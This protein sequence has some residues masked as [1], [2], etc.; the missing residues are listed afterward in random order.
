MRRYD[1]DYKNLVTR[2]N[3]AYAQSQGDGTVNLDLFEKMDA[4]KQN[5]IENMPYLD[6]RRI[7]SKVRS[8]VL[9]IGYLTK[10][11]KQLLEDIQNGRKTKYRQV[12]FRLVGDVDIKKI[13]KQY[14]QFM[15]KEQVF[16]T[17]YL[18]KGLQE[19]V[20]VVCENREQVFPIHDIRNLNHEK[21]LFFLK[22]VLA[23]G[24][25]REFHIEDD[26]VLCLQGYL[27]GS[28]EMMVV[29]SI[30]PYVAYPTGIRGMLYKIFDGMRPES[31]NVP[32]I[33]EE[34]AQKI[35][36]ERTKI[37]KAKSIEYWKGLMLPLGKSMK[38]PGEGAE[39]GKSALYKGLDD[40]L[41]QTLTAFC[42]KHH[43]S[44]KAA[45][46]FAWGNL[47]GKYHDEKNP[48]MLVAQNGNAMNLFPIK[49]KRDET[50]LENMRT[51]DRQL[52]DMMSYSDC[53]TRDMESAVGICFPEYFRMVHSFI[54]FSELDDI[55]AMGDGMTT[56]RGIG[57]DD[58][59]INLFIGYRLFDKNIG[60]HYT[61]RSGIS[62][63]VLE[64]LHELFVDELS[65]M[66]SQKERKFDKNFFI[67]AGDTDE[68]KLYKISLAQI[69]LYLKDSGVFESVTVDEIMQLAE[70][71][72][73]TTYLSNDTVIAERSGTS[74]I[75]ILGDGTVEESI[76]AA[77]GMVKS[78][79]IIKKGSV[80]G[81]E[82]LLAGGEA[83]TTYTVI[84]PQAKIVEIDKD[85]LA[86]VFRRKPEGW[87][88]L[89][90]REMDQKYRLQR[91]WTME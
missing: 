68:E 19:P 87:L 47:M 39:V 16:R 46:L 48:L 23:A 57:A 45:F 2:L 84:S 89:L 65:L 90:E 81:C 86:E 37:L 40:N 70:H 41:V 22:N 75:Y 10:E 51:V 91:L 43:I 66:L 3:Q 15:M 33:D 88:A 6:I 27:T 32:A 42:K 59:D 82:G 73:L 76:T 74:S 29:V 14:E 31:S 80:F 13:M 25:R 9:D 69:G 78:L 49:L 58:T 63:F 56:V 26:P 53:T 54:E 85:I 7:G 64:N 60:I 36:E 11:E 83:R 44:V 12:V 1:E 21:Q 62:E 61:A 24:M 72:S 20:R 35:S 8:N 67:Q 4:E 55:E 30:Y 28:K 34:A 38:L 17:V 77:D 50:A 5:Y 52:R 79:R 71:C 18:Y